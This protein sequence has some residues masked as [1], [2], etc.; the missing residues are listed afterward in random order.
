MNECSGPGNP[1]K[2]RGGF[3]YQLGDT[4]L[5]NRSVCLILGH[6]LEKAQ[7]ICGIITVC[8]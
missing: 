2:I 4:K 6:F 7:H 3:K 1:L 8:G 5:L